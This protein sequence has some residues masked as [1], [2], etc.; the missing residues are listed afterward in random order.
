[1]MVLTPG[2]GGMPP[3]ITSPPGAAIAHTRASNRVS[4]CTAVTKRPSTVAHLAGSGNPPEIAYDMVV[5]RRP[6]RRSISRLRRATLV[7]K[8]IRSLVANDVL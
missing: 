3:K 5:M 6:R 1:M 2:I 4:S 7:A 8:L